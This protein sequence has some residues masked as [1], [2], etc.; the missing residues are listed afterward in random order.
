MVGGRFRPFSARCCRRSNLSPGLPPIES[1]AKDSPEN[2]LFWVVTSASLVV[3]SATLVV[4]S[5]AS[6][7]NKLIASCYTSSKALVTT[8]DALVTNSFL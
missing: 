3:T 4:T 8:S 1:F 7:N 5:F 2:V 6:R